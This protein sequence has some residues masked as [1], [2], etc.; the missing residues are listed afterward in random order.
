MHRGAC[1][2]AHAEADYFV[3]SLT[4]AHSGDLAAP[5]QEFNPDLIGTGGTY[6]HSN[7]FRYC[8]RKR[9]LALCWRQSM[10]SAN[11][12]RSWS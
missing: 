5:G 7:T 9:D 10:S 4:F 11:A 2:L 1:D 8:G 6:T 12:G 3:A